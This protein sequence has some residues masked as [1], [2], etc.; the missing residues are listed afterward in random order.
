MSIQTLSPRIDVGSNLGKAL[1]QGFQS[2]AEN[3][4]QFNVN[5]SRLAEAFGKANP[6]SNFIENLQAIAPTLLSTPGGAQAL[7]ELAPVLGQYGKNSAIA[8]TI[9][10]RRNGGGNAQSDVPQTSGGALPATQSGFGPQAQPPQVNVNVPS[11]EQ[12][13]R[14]P[15]IPST[16][17]TTFPQRTAGPQ[18]KPRMSPQQKEDL[19]LDLMQESAQNGKPLPYAEAAQT[20][21]ALD[22]QTAAYNEQIQ[23]EKDRIEASQDKINE[24]IMNR[25]R[26][27]GAI[28]S[29]SPE[30]ETIAKKFANEAPNA[31]NENQRYEYVRDKMRSLES[32][33]DQITKMTDIANP[34]SKFYRKYLSGN[35]KDINQIKADLQA[36]LKFYRENGLWKEARN[37]ISDNV[38][39]GA[40]DTED[41]LFPM[42]K[43]QKADLN[44]FKDNSIKAKSSVPFLPKGMK[45]E[46]TLFPGEDVKLPA[47]SFSKFKD[48][49][50]DY[51]SKHDG[52]NLVSLRG[53]INQDKGYAW[54]DYSQAIN[55]LIDEKRFIPDT[56]QDQE[57]IYIK[58]APLPGLAQ[59]FRYVLKGTK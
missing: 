51:L 15:Q 17:N 45:T 56:A 20:I 18:P 31:A 4:L 19:I 44:N 58:N 54:Q 22:L 38:G 59:Q 43:D 16:A 57:M 2:G 25:L 14:R 39:F 24:G 40:E 49:L 28:S 8:K 12:A 35:Y 11:G 50:G 13:H 42:S 3:S 32:A 53:H 37:L 55:E 1:G 30:D 36:P 29:D 6:N 23:A 10:D 46:S 5:R 52:I 9:A 21:N 48:E 34:A 33:R 47:E 41:T 7:S 26:N 27:S